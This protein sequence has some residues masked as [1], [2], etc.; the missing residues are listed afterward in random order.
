[1]V[2]QPALRVDCRCDGFP[3]TGKREEERV[4]LRVDLGPGARTERV[5]DDPAVLACDLGEVVAQFLQKTRRSLDVREDE[6]DRAVGQCAHGAYATRVNR[7]AQETSPYLLQ[8]AHN[9]VDW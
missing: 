9:P 2:A 1:M 8:H 6:R 7:L 5:A 4:A 3:R